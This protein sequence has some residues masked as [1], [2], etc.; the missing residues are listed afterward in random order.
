MTKPFLMKKTS[1]GLATK[2]TAAHVV[3][4]LAHIGH[5]LLQPHTSK[6]LGAFLVGLSGD[7]NPAV[8]KCYA[9]AIG[10]LVKT[11]KDKSVE[12]LFTKLRSWYMDKDDHSSRMAVALTFQAITR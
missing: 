3:T 2:G 12:K 1:V 9:S 6:L 8:R 11:A 10:Q 4:H 5:E 7:R